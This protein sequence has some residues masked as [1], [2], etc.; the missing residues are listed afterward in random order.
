MKKPA[1]MPTALPLDSCCMDN[2]DEHRRGDQDEVGGDEKDPLE[3]L[4]PVVD[5]GDRS[6]RGLG[7]IELRHGPEHVLVREDFEVEEVSR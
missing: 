1:M 5:R 2:D 7:V 4:N 6:G 3:S